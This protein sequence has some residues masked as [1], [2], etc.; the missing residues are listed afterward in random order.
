MQLSIRKIV[1]CIAAVLCLG[2]LLLA[3]EIALVPTG[4]MEN[5]IL[6]GDHV[7]VFK[8]LDSPEI[9]GLH[10]RL[11]R[12]RSPQREDLV[13]FLSPTPSHAVYLKR[14]VAVAGDSVE[15]RNG[16]LYV[17]GIAVVESYAPRSRRE[18][19]LVPRCLRRGEIFVL[20]DNRDNSEDSRDFG[21]IPVSAV[22]G[23]PVA[24]VWSARARTPDL[25][26]TR[27]DVR[28]AFYW[29]VLRHPVGSVRWWRTGMLL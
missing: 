14:V 3:F 16:R 18:P 4:S 2:F 13:S 21:P 25:L 7:L 22:I 9:P 20:G 6:V 5:T 29:S 23:R 15:M 28:L 12:L 10:L 24:V 11:P 26:N 1:R 27:G 8:L 17:N 19:T